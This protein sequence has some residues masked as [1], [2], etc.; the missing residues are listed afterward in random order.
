MELKDESVPEIRR[1]TV[2]DYFGRN[3]STLSDDVRIKSGELRYPTTRYW[4]ECPMHGRYRLYD[5]RMKNSKAVPEKFKTY[6]PKC[7]E[8]YLS[9]D[10][11]PTESDISDCHEFLDGMKFVKSNQQVPK[12]FIKY[13][14]RFYKIIDSYHLPDIELSFYNKI[15]LFK[16]GVTEVPTCKMK[17][18]DKKVSLINVKSRFKIYCDDHALPGGKS[19]VELEMYYYITSKLQSIEVISG[20]ELNGKE[21]DVYVP[22]LKLGFEFNGIYHHRERKAFNRSRH[23]DKWKMFDNEGIKVVTVWED[24]WRGRTDVVKSMIDVQV[25]VVNGKVQARKCD[26]INLTTDQAKIFLEKNGLEGHVESDVNLGLIHD[27]EIACVMTISRFKD[28]SYKI[29]RLCSALNVIVQGGASKLFNNF[30]KSFDPSLVIAYVNLDISNGD[31]VFSKI[32]FV[33]SG[34]VKPSYWMTRTKRYTINQFK[35]LERTTKEKNFKVWDSGKI[36]Y[37]WRKPSL[38]S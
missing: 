34:L 15:C 33:P 22:S 25:G 4:Y 36:K 21:L 27:G 1:V 6:C 13:L 29:T 28:S 24:D 18:C 9:S 19:Q 12:Y 11:V 31:N 37:E 38:V 7:R 17:G 8:L 26:V 23:Y 14:P 30:I 35:K 3:V 16:R 20:Y 10:Y 5:Y 2:K 32:G